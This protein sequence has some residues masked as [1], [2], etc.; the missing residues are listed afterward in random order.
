[1]ERATE[2]GGLMIQL[3]EQ[4]EEAGGDDGALVFNERAVEIIKEISAF[5]KTT[6]AYE[7]VSGLAA[8]FWSHPHTAEDVWMFILDRV[9]NAPARIYADASVLWHMPALEEAIEK[10]KKLG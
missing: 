9:A 5:S 1:M 7:G 2:V 10:E 6:D 8:E 3:I 4:V